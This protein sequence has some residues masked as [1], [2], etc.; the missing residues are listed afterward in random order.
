MNERVVEAVDTTVRTVV[1]VVVAGLPVHVVEFAMVV[2]TTVVVV[3]PLA[4]MCMMLA[5]V[6]VIA[7]VGML[8]AF[9]VSPEGWARR[10]FVE[11]EDP[12]II[13]L[14]LVRVSEEVDHRDTSGRAHSLRPHE[15]FR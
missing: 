12:F 1:R 4:T 10:V 15:L 11:E 7:L 14:L 8:L 6:S 2:V 13:N 9:D 3:K 5:T